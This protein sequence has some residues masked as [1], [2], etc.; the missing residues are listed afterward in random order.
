MCTQITCYLQRC[1]TT[2]NPFSSKNDF[3][4]IYKQFKIDLYI[5]FCMVQLKHFFHWRIVKLI[6]SWIYFYMLL[7]KWIGWK[8]MDEWFENEVLLQLIQCSSLS[9]IPD[10]NKHLF[11]KFF[12]RYYFNIIISFFISFNK[13]F[14]FPVIMD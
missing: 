9:M 2:K 7:Y 12:L 3:F 1:L 5:H 11:L 14:V 10:W 8:V 6:Y 13:M 4:F